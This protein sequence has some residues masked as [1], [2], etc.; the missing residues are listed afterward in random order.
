MSISSVT[1]SY[2]AYPRNS[3]RNRSRPSR[4]AFDDLGSALLSG[5]LPAAREAFS[6]LQPW[7][8]GMQPDGHGQTQD[9]GTQNPLGSHLAAL[10]KALQSGDLNAA[11]E[12]FAK[13]RHDML[14]ALQERQHSHD[15]QSPGDGSEPEAGAAGATDAD[16]FG[17]KGIDVT[18]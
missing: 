11:R 16:G 2:G 7:L 14:A 10:G 3:A 15:P 17:Y 18:A 6:A 12:V 4:Q 9:N 8:R 1:A 13:L 5:D